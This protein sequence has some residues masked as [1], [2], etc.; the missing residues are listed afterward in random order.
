MVQPKPKNMTR[1][2]KEEKVAEFKK[3]I[4]DYPVVG[5]LDMQSLPSRQLQEMKKEMKEFA[6][7][8]MSRKTL[9]DIAIEKAEKKDIEQLE[10]T[11]A[12]QPAFIFSNKDPFQ[13]YSLIKKNKTSA[14]AQGG[15]I[16]PSD[17]EVPEGDTGIGPGPMLGKLQQTGAQVQ[18]DDG[19][20]HVMKSA[21]MIE[22]GDTI[23]RDDA[24]ILN[25][26]G[27]EPLEIGLDLDIAFSDGELFT[28]EELDIDTEE[29][30][31]DVESAASLAFN[32]A[33]NAGVVNETTAGTIVGEA[34]QK[35][36]NLSISEG[37][38]TDETI[39]EI[40]AH[41]SSN[42]EGLNSQ[43]DL[44]SVDLEESEDSE[45]EDTDEDETEES[46]EKEE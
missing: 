31:T 46:E 13:L 18:V 34:A 19:T 1:S 9:M 25:Q 21:T 24:E 26:L 15:E 8:K 17:I 36:R 27:L 14:A 5:I 28:A 16:A 35:A 30:R 43:V 10:E 4:E 22:K 3:K 33:V 37:I 12:V 6:D 45:Q 23:T 7:I 20:I 38:P 42:A 39:E 41:A 2:Q 40:L 11:E 44:D 29:Y 32:L